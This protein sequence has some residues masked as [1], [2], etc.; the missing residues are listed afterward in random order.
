[1]TTT[2]N[3]EQKS[4]ELIT[5]IRAYGSGRGT[6][7][8]R[9]DPK[10]NVRTVNMI[11]GGDA[12]DQQSV[13]KRVK[14]IYVNDS[15]I[16]DSIDYAFGSKAIRT[17]ADGGKKSL[18]ALLHK[19]IKSHSFANFGKKS[20]FTALNPIGRFYARNHEHY[21][22]WRLRDIYQGLKRSLE[23]RD[24]DEAY[25]LLSKRKLQVAESCNGAVPS[26]EDLIELDNIN[27]Q[28]YCIEKFTALGRKRSQINNKARGGLRSRSSKLPDKLS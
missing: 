11:I 14:H 23:G 17:P 22:R 26:Y 19:A 8:T 16:R 2:K 12:A 5:A 24:L 28:L 21:E 9:S 15:T 7:A 25:A 6:E 20:W 18:L 3:N 1:M 10:T 13:E 4:N 27:E